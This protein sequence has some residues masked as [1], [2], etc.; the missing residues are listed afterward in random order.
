MTQKLFR[1]LLISLIWIATAC[2]ALLPPANTNT[3]NNNAPT[4]AAEVTSVEPADV[5]QN[6]ISAWNNEDF[7]AMYRL[8]L[9]PIFLFI[10]AFLIYTFQI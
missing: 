6:F 1:M 9:F 7:E 3:G 2:D 8:F 10:F 5:L 4:Q